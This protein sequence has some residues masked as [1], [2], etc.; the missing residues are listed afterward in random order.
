MAIS[1]QENGAG[2]QL[3]EKFSPVLIN[4]RYLVDMN[5]PII[6]LDTPSAKAYAVED[7]RNQEIP[8]FALVCTPGLPV[9]LD[10]IQKLR[11]ERHTGLM[12]LISWRVSFWPPINQETIVV[13]Y[14]RPLGGSLIEALKTD[15]FEITEYDIQAT[16]I[17]PIFQ[18][19]RELSAKNIPHRG[20]RVENIFFQDKERKE[21]VLGDCITCPPAFNQPIIYEPVQRAMASPGGRG[22]G[23]LSDDL[24]ALGVTIVILIF[25]KNVIQYKTSQELLEAKIE[26]GSY[27]ALCGK[28]R[29]LLALLELLRGILSDDVLERWDIE[30]VDLWIAGKRQTPM[31]RK[32]SIKS[33]TPYIFMG[34]EYFNPRILAHAFTLNVKEGADSIKD[35]SLAKWLK[36]SLDKDDLS[37]SISALAAVAELQKNQVRGSDDYVVTKASILMDPTGPI[38]YKGLS[39]VPDGYGSALA[40]DLLRRNSMQTGAEILRH[41]IPEIWYDAPTEELRD[42]N[43]FG[44]QSVF[45]KMRRLLISDGPGF[46]IERCLYELNSSL[47]CQSP[48]ISG[49]YVIN[50][51]DLLPALDTAANQIDKNLRPLDRHVTA[52]IAARF[53]E[54]ID[55][56]LKKL[57]EQSDT[58][59]LN[60]M[61][62]LLAHIQWK[63][64]LDPLFELTKWVGSLLDP[65]IQTYFSHTTRKEIREALPEVV[66]Q[67]SLPVLFDLIDNGDKRLKDSEDYDNAK[68]EYTVADE[69]IKT[70]E[71]G[72]LASPEAPIEQGQRIAALTSLVI[73]MIF[74]SILALSELL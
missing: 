13:I 38:R 74:I 17:E 71:T 25:G 19:I 12:Q 27:A 11:R 42:D 18:T 51:N 44:V 34:K 33:I 52:F 22:R 59:F 39:F 65:A 37:Q 23:D 10:I 35:E 57:S 41:R 53:K 47:S 58:S 50:I 5:S 54:P 15:S 66:S 30:K 28:Q 8:L 69:Q 64:K 49:Q 40:V 24:Y 31:Q 61:I 32:A 70:I 2:D 7:Q 3:D 26:Q 56:H 63:L 46:G 45:N 43:A 20:I 55:R 9:R 16:I 14:E 36:K 68:I 62:N 1:P 6:S 72:D 73:S 60:G 48:L 67:G 4:D 29:I 21:I